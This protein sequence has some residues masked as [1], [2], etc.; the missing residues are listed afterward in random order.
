MFTV[1]LSESPVLISQILHPLFISSPCILV[2]L[3]KD[4]SRRGKKETVDS[5]V[6]AIGESFE[7]VSVNSTVLSFLKYFGYLLL[8]FATVMQCDDILRLR[9]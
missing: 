5:K 8:K 2:P 6:E 3:A 4:V 1:L 9:V 7:A